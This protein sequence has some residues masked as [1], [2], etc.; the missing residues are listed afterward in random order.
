MKNPSEQW[1]ILIKNAQDTRRAKCTFEHFDPLWLEWTNS[2]KNHCSHCLY[3]SCV[4]QSD[5]FE[6]SPSQANFRAQNH[7]SSTCGCHMC[8]ER[9]RSCLELAWW[10]FFQIGSIFFLGSFSIGSCVVTSS[11]KRAI[12]FVHWILVAN[13]DDLFGDGPFSARKPKCR[14]LLRVAHGS[15]LNFELFAI[16]AKVP[17]S[18]VDNRESLWFYILDWEHSLCPF[19]SLKLMQK[20]GFL[21]GEK[22]WE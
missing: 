17:D 14:A 1:A 13:G 16:I 18:H 19:V 22:V 11:Q 12:F 6:L 4:P 8:E 3:H 15:Q 7:L 9:F 2:A 20:K 5:N 10:K 21:R